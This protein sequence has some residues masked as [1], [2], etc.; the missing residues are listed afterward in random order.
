MHVL[1]EHG[2]VNGNV[3]DEQLNALHVLQYISHCLTEYLWWVYKSKKKDFFC[4]KSP[5]GILHAVIHP[6]SSAGGTHSEVQFSESCS[7]RPM[8]TPLECLAL[9]QQWIWWLCRTCGNHHICAHVHPSY[10]QLPLDCSISWTFQFC[11]FHVFQLL[12]HSFHEFDG[13]RIKLSSDWYVSSQLSSVTTYT[14]VTWH[15]SVYVKAGMHQLY[16]HSLFSC[17]DLLIMS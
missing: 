13:H 17:C 8:H 14:L 10:W 16:D 6:L 5:Q 3:T 2:W 7:T 1:F 4:W 11:L 12:L 9:S 15:L